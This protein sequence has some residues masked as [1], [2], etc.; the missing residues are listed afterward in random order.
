[1]NANTKNCYEIISANELAALRAELAAYRAL[2]I[3]QMTK[4]QSDRFQHELRAAR[5]IAKNQQS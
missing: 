3:P 2:P 1:M 5:L 4:S